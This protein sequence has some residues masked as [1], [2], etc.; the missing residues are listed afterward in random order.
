MLTQAEKKNENEKLSKA[1]SMCICVLGVCFQNEVA[2]ALAE[3]GYSIFAWKGES[4]DD[5]WWSIDKCIHTDNW[6]P[7]MVK[8]ASEKFHPS[9]V[10]LSPF[11]LLLIMSYEI[12]LS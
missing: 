12:L 9:V 4:E 2:A 1:N 11:F 8:T 10:S 3:A 6:Q 5:F 7:N